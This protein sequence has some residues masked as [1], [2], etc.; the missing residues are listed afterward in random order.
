MDDATI[1]YAQEIINVLNA[2]Q[3]AIHLRFHSILE[4][5]RLTVAQYKVLEHLF[6]HHPNGL[7]V[8]ELSEHLGLAKSTISGIV[9]RVE[10]DGWV[11]REPNPGDARK[12]I[13]QLT[14]KGIDIFEKI[15]KDRED[16]WRTT[17]GKLNGDEQN[18]L[19]E[20]L[21]KLEKIMEK[22]PE[23]EHRFTM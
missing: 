20:L 9:D 19:L 12:I 18:T 16:F 11:K 8:K 13:V 23:I 1:D 4:P 22:A 3:N 6:W 2:A 10:R 14:Q 5:Y 15:P 17:I 7:G 21:K